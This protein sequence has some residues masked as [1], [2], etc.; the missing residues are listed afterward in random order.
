MRLFW[1][2]VAVVFAQ[3]GSTIRVPVR[4]VSVPTLV[5]SKDGQLVPGLQA[6][7]FRVYDNGRLQKADLETM[8]APVSV[9][10]AV[11]MNQDVRSYVPFIGKAGSAIEALLAGESGETMVIAYNDDVTVVKSFDNIKRVPANG[12]QARMIDAGLRGIALLKERPASRARVLLFIGQPIDSG[13]ESTLAFLKERAETANVTVYA[14]TLP[15]F[16]KAFV[17]DTIQLSG[18]SAQEKGG[19]K[20]G[21]DLGRLIEV[22]GRSSKA[23]EG[24]DPFSV[25]TAATGGTPIYFRKQRELESAIATLGVELRSGYLLSYYPSS[26]APGYHTIDIEV[27]ISGARVHSRPGYFRPSE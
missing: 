4:L 17:S 24:A 19:F 14:L 12:R 10:V 23:E 11:Q 15:Q 18:V 21:L 7:D 2:P 1:L 3:Q 16:G 6:S 9:A 25:L 13:S 8:S 26:T 5:L 20:A 27:D 22:L